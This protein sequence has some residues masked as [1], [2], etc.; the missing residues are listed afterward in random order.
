MEQVANTHVDTCKFKQ[1]SLKYYISITNNDLQLLEILRSVLNNYSVLKELLDFVLDGNVIS[2][3]RALVIGVQTR[4]DSFDYL[5]V[6]SVCELVLSHGY[7]LSTA[8]Q[9]N[10]I[11]EAEANGS[12]HLPPKRLKSCVQVKVSVF[13]G[14]W[15][16]PRQLQF[17][18]PIKAFSSSKDASAV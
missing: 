16:K 1:T 5:F 14:I 12:Q 10:T 18:R 13:L 3:V 4:M 11:S 8:F 9:N 17:T 2:D 7:N 6:V 15:Y